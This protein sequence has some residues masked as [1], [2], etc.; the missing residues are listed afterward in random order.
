MKNN[1]YLVQK[2]VYLTRTWVLTGDARMPLI[3]KWVETGTPGT[4]A[5]APA[6]TEAGRLHLCA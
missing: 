1:L 6:D 2:T 3:C 5:V 4:V